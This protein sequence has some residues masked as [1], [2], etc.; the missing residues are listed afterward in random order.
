MLDAL[1]QPAAYL[2][3]D[4]PG[5]PTQRIY[6]REVDHVLIVHVCAICLWISRRNRGTVDQ[7]MDR[8]YPM[9]DAIR[10]LHMFPLASTESLKLVHKYIE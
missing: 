3:M 7:P 6:P 2:C 8:S 9:T 1:I 4:S 5:F 10:T